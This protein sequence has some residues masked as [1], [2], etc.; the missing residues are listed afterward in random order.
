MSWLVKWLWDLNMVNFQSNFLKCY[1]KY[2]QNGF[3]STKGFK[4]SGLRYT[5]KILFTRFIDLGQ[6]PKLGW[7]LFQ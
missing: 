7:A 6:N 3:H 5:L 2:Y 1:L 4:K